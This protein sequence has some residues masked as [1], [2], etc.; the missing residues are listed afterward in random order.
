QFDVKAWLEGPHS[1]DWILV[2]D[3]AD[4]KSDFLCEDE[5][6]VEGAT[7]T[8]YIPQGYK[9]TVIVTTRDH[10]VAEE[11]GGRNSTRKQNM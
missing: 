6:S 1:G 11:L 2:L 3:N 10:E 4:D 5:E 7:L 9:G 8:D